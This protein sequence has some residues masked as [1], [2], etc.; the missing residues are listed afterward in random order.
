[1][2]SRLPPIQGTKA[3]PSAIADWANSVLNAGKSCR[4]RRIDIAA[5]KARVRVNRYASGALAVFHG[6]RGLAYFTADGTP[7]TEDLQQAA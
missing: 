4:F 3:D 2:S 5:V 6:P 1:M 7:I